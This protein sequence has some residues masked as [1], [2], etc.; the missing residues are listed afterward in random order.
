MDQELTDAA[1]YA[2]RTLSMHSLDG[3]TFV[4][5]MTLWTPSCDLK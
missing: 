3:S 4:C 5:E 1:A 2:G